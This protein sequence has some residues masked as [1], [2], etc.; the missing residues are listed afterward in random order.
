MMFKLMAPFYDSF[1]RFTGIDHS[2]N[3]PDWLA[4]VKDMEVLDLAGGTG[5]NAE[6]L[7]KAGAKV[8]VA[9]AS[10]AMLK[11]AAAKKMTAHIL[12][13]KA[14]DL[15]LPDG[16]F[17]IVLISDA[18]H[19][20]RNQPGVIS[21]VMRVLRPS[22]RLYIIDFDAGKRRTKTLAFFERLLFEP[23]AF[24][25]PGELAEKLRRA[26]LEGG[27]RGLKLDQFIYKGTKK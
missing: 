27:W 10:Q 2:H 24:P 1:I 18:W 15:P 8:T 6:T 13:A 23:S 25:E 20:F 9:D 7:S 16:S 11:R 5:M 26:G 21:E 14:E 4:P 22:G 12:H 3:I 19:H 17:D